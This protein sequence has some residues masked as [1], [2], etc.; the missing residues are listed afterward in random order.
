MC[1]CVRTMSS[2]C[3][4]VHNWLRCELLCQSTYITMVTFRIRLGEANLIWF[5]LLLLP[6]EM[7]EMFDKLLYID[8][9][10]LI[11]QTLISPSLLLPPP[12]PPPSRCYLLKRIL[13]AHILTSRSFPALSRHVVFSTCLNCSFC[14]G[15]WC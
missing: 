10:L 14:S 1:V 6:R 9:S 13:F 8:L 4:T 2:S 7:T 5:P 11:S 12:P 15:A 3:H